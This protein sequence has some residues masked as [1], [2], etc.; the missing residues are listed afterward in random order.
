MYIYIFFKVRASKAKPQFIIAL[1]FTSIFRV[2]LLKLFDVNV[3]CNCR[4]YL[5]LKAQVAIETLQT[6]LR[7]SIL[8]E[9][10]VVLYSMSLIELKAYRDCRKLLILHY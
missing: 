9:R 4:L 2:T 3:Y 6:Q 10:Y 8:L 7:E 5:N 1:Y